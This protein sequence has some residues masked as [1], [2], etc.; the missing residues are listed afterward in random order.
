MQNHKTGKKERLDNYLVEQGYFDTKSQAQGAI[1]AA[2]VKVNGEFLTKA[3][4][5][6]NKEKQQNIEIESLPYVSRGGFKLEKALKEFNIDLKG[7]VCLDA[8]ASTGGFTDCMLQ[9]GA[10]K[11]YAIDVGYGQIAWKLRNDPKVEVIE[12]TNIRNATAE[13]IY[14]GSSDF[15]EFCAMDL[16]FI[17]ITK[18]IENVKTLMNPEKHEI[19]ALIKPQFEAGKDQ[20]PKS[21]VIRDKKIH[22]N[23]INNIINF[24][25]TINL[26]PVNLDYSPIQGPAGNIEYLIHL[27]KS[28]TELY[29]DRQ[30]LDKLIEETVEKAHE[31]FNQNKIQ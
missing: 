19:V 12:R 2:K 14:K 20:V 29:F 9:N 15:A 3:G 23:V 21:G 31:H 8:G 26:S 10:G 11:V 18:V 16:S 27:K 7:K 25:C 4:T 1:L 6:I 13:E 17:S 5:L 24:A 28:D 30:K 22:V